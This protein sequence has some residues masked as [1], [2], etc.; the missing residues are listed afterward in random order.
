[1]KKT[2]WGKDARPEGMMGTC[3]ICLGGLW[4][5]IELARL[6]QKSL[7]AALRFQL[8]DLGLKELQ[9]RWHEA[10][11]F[12]STKLSKDSFWVCSSEMSLHRLC[13][14]DTL[15]LRQR[16]LK[17]KELLSTFSKGL[18]IFVLGD[19]KCRQLL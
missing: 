17:R 8:L 15:L 1:M 18:G 11:C 2:G 16:A 19:P 13:L 5:D 14:D 12:P 7:D 3:A 4:V 10:G 9:E 6:H